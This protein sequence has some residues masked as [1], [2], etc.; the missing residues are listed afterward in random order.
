[1]FTTD[2]APSPRPYAD[3]RAVLAPYS[4]AMQRLLR[5]GGE[6]AQQRPSGHHRGDGAFGRDNGGAIPSTLLRVAN[7]SSNDRYTRACPEA[8]LPVHPARFPEEMP[9]FVI[10]FLTREDDLVIDPMCGSGRTAR[11][12]DG[13]GRRWVCGDLACEYLRGAAFRLH[14]LPGFVDHFGPRPAVARRPI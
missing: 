2:V 14:D 5:R 12:A 13:L 1:L 6:A 7:T 9:E 8:G 11:A 10:R 4:E 3:N